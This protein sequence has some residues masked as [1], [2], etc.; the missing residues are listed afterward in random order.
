MSF[1]SKIN[2]YVS[3]NR[4]NCLWNSYLSLH[5]ESGFNIGNSQSIQ[6]WS[7]IESQRNG[8]GFQFSFTSNSLKSN[9]YQFLIGLN[10]ASIVC[11]YISKAYVVYDALPLN[12]PLNTYCIVET[13]SQLYMNCYW[14][15]LKSYARSKEQSVWTDTWMT[16]SLHFLKLLGY[17]SCSLEF[18]RLAYQVLVLCYTI[19]IG[20]PAQHGASTK[21]V[22]FI[23]DWHFIVRLWLDRRAG[24]S[25]ASQS[26]VWMF[27]S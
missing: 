10:I 25:G 12:P 14:S 26:Y 11:F 3:I 15:G 21:K 1:N 4:E 6:I 13:S 2:I 19:Y 7:S 9:Q 18:F 17:V 8:Q 5:W 23:S 16:F 20:I 27:N 22:S 24:D